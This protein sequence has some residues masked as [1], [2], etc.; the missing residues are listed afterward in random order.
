MKRFAALAIF[1]VL[2][3]QAGDTVYLVPSGAWPLCESPGAPAALCA[4]FQP[5]REQYMLAVRA[6]SD[7]TQR[8]VIDLQVTLI[9]GIV[10]S[11]SAEIARA[12]NPAGITT[13]VLFTGGVV[14]SYRVT[15]HEFTEVAV[16]VVQE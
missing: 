7:A 6:K 4:G 1:T 10:R 2:S 3:L 13:L 9:D 14:A 11:F 5:G 12:D 15:V 16:T 8:Y